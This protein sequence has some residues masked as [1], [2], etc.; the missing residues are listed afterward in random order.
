MRPIWL[1][2]FLAILSLSWLHA[3]ETAPKYPYARTLTNSNDVKLPVTIVGRNA[4]DVCF[5]LRS[6]PDKRTRLYPIVLLSPEDQQFLAQTPEGGSM[7]VESAEAASYR[8]KAEQEIAAVAEKLAIAKAR[9]KKAATTGQRQAL[10]KD[11]DLLTARIK[12]LKKRLDARLE[13]FKD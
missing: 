10:E 2:G 9:A 4:R 13:L 1:A 12:D 11:V 6:D 8:H 7:E 5:Y 3:A